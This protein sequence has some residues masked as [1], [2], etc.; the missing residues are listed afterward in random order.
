MG[1]AQLE[2]HPRPRGAQVGELADQLH[3]RERPQLGAQ[4]HRVLSDPKRARQRAPRNARSRVVGAG[5]SVSLRGHLSMSLEG[6]A[7]GRRPA[8]AGPLGASTPVNCR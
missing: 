1:V 3:A 8:S 7:D 4:R 5:V 2:V 6:G